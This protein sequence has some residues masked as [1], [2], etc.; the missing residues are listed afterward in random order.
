MSCSHKPSHESSDSSDSN[1][2]KCKKSS[3]KHIK[4]LEH[5]LKKDINSNA[6]G[7]FYSFTPQLI[8]PNEMVRF[9]KKINVLNLKLKIDGDKIKV[10][11]SGMYV[12]SFMIMT[13]SPSQFALFV[14]NSP[15]LSTVVY[16]NNCIHCNQIV[17]LYKDDLVSLC[18]YL[19]PT[20]VMTSHSNGLIPNS[21]NLELT[22]HRIAPI[23]C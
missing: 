17:E 11:Q 22:L 5:K 6:Y 19:S 20:D 12:V 7:T 10:Q 14:N 15:L 8:K 18:S 1:E 4:H 13:D 16:S 23:K 2:N 3:N 9:E 21:T